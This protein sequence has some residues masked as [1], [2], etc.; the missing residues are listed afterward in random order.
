MQSFSHE[1]STSVGDILRK[2]IHKNVFAFA[3]KDES[4]GVRY[5]VWRLSQV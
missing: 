1:L 4:S 5:P 2:Y 3:E